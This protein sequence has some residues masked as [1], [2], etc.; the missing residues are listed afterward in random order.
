MLIRQKILLLP[1]N[2]T[3]GTFDELQIVFLTKVNLLYF[4]YSAARRCCPL[5]LVK[6]KCFATKNF[7]LDYSG[8]S[9]PVFHSRTNLKLHNISLTPKMV[10]KVITNLDSSKVFGLDYIPVVVLN[11]CMPELS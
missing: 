6:Q 9:L 4:L 8:N 3:L 11:N 10:K 2:L 1:R 7:Y 5:H